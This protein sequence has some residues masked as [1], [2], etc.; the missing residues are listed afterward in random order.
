MSHIVGVSPK[1]GSRG[2]RRTPWTLLSPAEWIVGMSVRSGDLTRQCGL[3]AASAAHEPAQRVD[4]REDLESQ[5][6]EPAQVS[7]TGV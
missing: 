2:S 3:L 5:L 1:G 4:R 7:L 6:F